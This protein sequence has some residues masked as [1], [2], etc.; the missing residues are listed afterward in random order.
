MFSRRQSEASD[1]EMTIV[2]RRH[3][4]DIYGMLK[5]LAYG[6]RSG[7][8][9]ELANPAGSVPPIFLGPLSREA[10]NRG[11]LHVHQAEVAPKQP[12]GMGLL[13]KRPIGF[14]ENHAQADHA[15]PQTL[16]THVQFSITPTSDNGCYV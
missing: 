2:R 15:G 14:V 10:G 5:Q 9:G 16:F 4:H 7:E 3:A 12:L 1:F 13:E 6:L 8:A 11:Q